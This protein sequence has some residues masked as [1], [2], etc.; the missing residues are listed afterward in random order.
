MAAAIIDWQLAYAHVETAVRESVSEFPLPYA[1]AGALAVNL[2]LLWVITFGTWL[3]SVLTLNYSHVDRLWSITPFLYVWYFVYRAYLDDGAQWNDRLVLMG[4]L[5]TAWGLRLTYNFA[6][7]GGYS[8]ND[9][10]YRWGVLRSKMHPILFQLFNI[11]FIAFY[12]HLLLFLIVFP[13][14]VAYVYRLTPLNDLDYVAAGLFLAFL[15]LETIADQQQWTYYQTKYALLA[16]KATLTGDYKVGF[17]RSGLFAYSRHPNFFAEQSIWCAFY[18]FSVA[19]SSVTW[20]PSVIGAV[21]LILLFQG[22]TQFTEYITLGKYP[23]Y[24]TYQQQVSRLVP[25]FPAKVAKKHVE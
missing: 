10:D 11:T 23:E 25:W 7:K 2:Q 8:L 19:S 1:T 17:N 21:L 24:K 15:T 9:E 4:V 13:A 18:V 5:A 20:N 16:K 3:A 6:R 12:Q 14:Y 22:S